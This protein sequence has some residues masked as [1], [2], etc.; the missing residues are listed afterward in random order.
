MIKTTCDEK[1]SRPVDDTSHIVPLI[2]RQ[3]LSKS[4]PALFD[5]EKYL[6]NFIKWKNVVKKGKSH[7]SENQRGH[8]NVSEETNFKT[9]MEMS[10][11]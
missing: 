1:E 7:I 11:P 4:N 6:Q 5:F 3:S 10:N 2:L 9:K 8:L